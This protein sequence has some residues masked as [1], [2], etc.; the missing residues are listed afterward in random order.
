M[1]DAETFSS[2]LFG[3]LIDHSHHSIAE[4]KGITEATDVLE[5]SDQLYPMHAGLL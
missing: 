5:Q 4:E 2:R 1:K 3:S